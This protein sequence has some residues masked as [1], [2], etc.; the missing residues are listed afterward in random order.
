MRAAKNFT[1]GL[2]DAEGEAGRVSIRANQEIPD[3]YL[4]Q[5]PDELILEKVARNNP[6]E[7][8]RDQLMELAG[9]ND[10]DSG[11]TEEV[12]EEDEFD[13]EEFR[14]G[15]SEFDTKRALIDWAEEVFGLELDQDDTRAQLEDQIVAFAS[16]ADEDE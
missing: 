2:A 14:E 16:G 15:L 8:T 12:D 7:L 5:V 11:E 1:L 9:L 4:D 3:E 13:E 10:S 6:Q